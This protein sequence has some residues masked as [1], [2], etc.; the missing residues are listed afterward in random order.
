MRPW[1][2]QNS[3]NSLIFSHVEKNWQKKYFFLCRATPTAWATHITIFFFQIHVSRYMEF[4][5]FFKSMY[6][7]TWNFDISS[8]PCTQVHDILIIF[9]TILMCSSGGG[10]GPAQKKNF[11]ANFFQHVKKLINFGNFVKIKVAKFKLNQT[12]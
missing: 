5:F 3:Q 1:S 7:G 8:N 12:G 9:F 10:G 11:F 4:C 6:P 2:L